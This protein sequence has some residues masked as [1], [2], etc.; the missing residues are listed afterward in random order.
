[1]YR[2]SLNGKSLVD[3]LRQSRELFGAKEC[4]K[5]YRDGRFIGVTYLDF[6]DWAERIARGLLEFGLK[7]GDKVAI[8]SANRPDWGATYLGVLLAGGINVPIDA[9]L[10][11]PSWSHIIHASKAKMLVISKSFL[12]ELESK[13]D[14]L[15]DL[16]AIVCM[17]DIDSGSRAISL[18]ELAIRGKQSAKELPDIDPSDTASILYT[19]GT[20]GQA[21]GVLLTHENI[22]SDIDGMTRL[23]TILEDDIFLSVLPIHH[24]FECTCGFL[25][26]LA[27]GCCIVYA[28]GLASKL[29]IEDIKNN[30]ATIILGVPLLYEKMHDG[31]FRAISKKP[32]FTKIMFKATYSISKLL[33][34]TLIANPGKRIFKGLRNKAG[35]DSLRL[36]IAGGAPMPPEV[37]KAFK[38]LGFCF[39]QGYGLSEAAPVLT[40]NPIDSKNKDASIGLPVPGAELKIIDPD[41]RGIGQIVA[42]G[43][44]VM[45]GYYDNPEATCEVL[46]DGWLYTGDSGWVDGDGYFYIAGRL[47]NVIVTP[48]GK[49]VYPEEIE[50]ELHKSPFILE[51]LVLGRRLEG[52]RG[53]EIEAVVVP[54]Y[55]YFNSL[56][57]ETNHKYTTEEIEKIIKEEVFRL[58]SGLAEFKRVKYI[59]IRE[60]EFEKTSTKKI[61]RY[62]FTQ[63]S[64]P[65]INKERKGRL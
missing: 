12:A 11:A 56:A 57:A 20:T 54:D 55:E 36:L 37:T 15:P 45:Q 52:T 48:A 18:H 64:E 4:M 47:K 8:L 50:S 27:Y 2:V 41:S 30:Q 26:P 19:S 44:M 16:Q 35:L 42:R 13:F 60:D 25:T 32:P 3:V 33:S 38:L 46:K 40:L 14:E 1:L 61:K 17:D 51:S 62:L 6:A 59:Q 58:S 63:K 24:A 43:P 28:R 9:L 39:T 29:I 22:V 49:N 21:K 53:E 5:S 23:I 65:I 7:K 31:I 34:A 10:K